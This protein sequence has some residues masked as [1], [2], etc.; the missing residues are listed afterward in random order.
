[1]NYP[2]EAIANYVVESFFEGV[3]LPNLSRLLGFGRGVLEKPHWGRPAEMT[4]EEVWERNVRIMN[5]I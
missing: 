3:F 4:A 5:A 1:M 2:Q